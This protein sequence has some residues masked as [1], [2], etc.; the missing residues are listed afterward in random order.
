MPFFEGDDVRIHYEFD[1]IAHGPVL[2]LSHSLGTDLSMW[3][4]Q[5]PEF[6]KHFSVLRYDSRGHGQ[7]SAPPGPYSIA[8]MSRDV[9]ALLDELD[10]NRAHFCGLSM[11]GMV[12]QW[13]GVHAAHRLDKL[14]LSNTAAKIG[15]ESMWN[16]RIE[17][18]RQHG[19]EAVIP[20]ILERWYTE[21]FRARFPAEMVRASAMLKS[22]NREGYVS[23]CAAVRDMDQRDDV[24]KISLPTLVIVG[25][26]DPVTP[27]SD[28]N[29][30]VENI[31]GAHALELHASH[32]ANIE[33]AS[34]FTEGVVDFLLGSGPGNRKGN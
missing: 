27:P 33:A 15:N 32:L 14:I 4:A 5:V 30:L 31:A 17:T 19:I 16:Q 29:F 18:V 6:A 24:K 20:A 25:T 13:L 28:A 22:I 8:Q 9:I 21:S 3:S 2:V 23:S 10:I 12:G 7:S 34:A 11:G 26:G 1:Q